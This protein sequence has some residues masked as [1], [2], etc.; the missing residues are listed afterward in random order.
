MQCLVFF[1]PFL[2]WVKVA[3]IV[4]ARVTR[5]VVTQDAGVTLST[6]IVIWT[7]ILVVVARVIGRDVR[8][9]DVSARVR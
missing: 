6:D 1:L 2:S 4:L 9:V 5:S 8:T 7:G 3:A